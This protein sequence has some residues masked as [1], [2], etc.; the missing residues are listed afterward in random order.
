MPTVA[1]RGGLGNQLFQYAVGRTLSQR[2]E[3]TLE[4]ETSTLSPSPSSVAPSRPLHLRDV[5]IQGTF[6]HTSVRSNPLLRGRLKLY[7]LTSKISS[8]L[9]TSIWRVYKEQHPQRFDPR[10]L[11]LSGDTYLLGYFQSERYFCEISDTLRDEL[12]LQTTTGPSHAWKKRIETTNSVGVHVRR[13]DYVQRGWTLPFQYY[14]RAIETMRSRLQDIE[15]FF[16]SDQIE[17]VKAH[18]EHLLPDPSASPPIH[19]VDCNSEKDTLEAFG[20]MKRCRHHVIA[21]STFSWW[22]AWLN[23]TEDKVVLAPAYW[24][25]DRVD[26][27]DI[28][29][30]R[31]TVVDW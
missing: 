5:P 6:V 14:Q 18:T 20:L 27:L 9:A 10:V 19:C 16:F 22:A 3:S 26:R 31:W 29:P 7:S 23:S 17:W 28:I 11:S 13:G 24:I 4:L 2:T 8:T 1:L 15:L 30:E 21:N 12:S 25:H